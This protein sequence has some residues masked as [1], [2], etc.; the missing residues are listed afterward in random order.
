MAYV[1]GDADELP[2][3]EDPGDDGECETVTCA[4][5][6]APYH[7]L[8]SV[9]PRCGRWRTAEDRRQKRPLWWIIVALL[10]AVAFAL[11]YVF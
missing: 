2:R 7:E 11:V 10:A 3:E 1:D 6:G 4:E 9:C 5:C 8:A